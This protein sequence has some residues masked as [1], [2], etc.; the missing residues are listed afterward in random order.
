MGNLLRKIIEWLFFKYVVD[1]YEEIDTV[2]H[3]AGP[4][5]EISYDPGGGLLSP[6]EIKDAM[7]YS[8]G[9]AV[10]LFLPKFD[11]ETDRAMW[12]KKFHTIH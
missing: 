7:A 8:F 1:H 6:D 2:E 9:G 5:F 11:N 3:D 12:E 4:E 10:E